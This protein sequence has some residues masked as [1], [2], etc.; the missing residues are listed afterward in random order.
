MDTHPYA[1]SYKED[2]QTGK[3]TYYVSKAECVPDTLATIAADV[4]QNLRSP[5]DQ[6]AYQLVLDAHSGTHPEDKGVVYYPITSAA[7][8]Y[9]ALRTR[10]MKA[11]RQEVID[12]IDATEPYK[13]GKGHALWQLNELNKPDKH[14][15]LV[16]MAF[17]SIG[18]DF[19]PTF[20]TALKKNPLW[21][22]RGASFEKLFA[23]MN[24]LFLREAGSGMA[25][26]GH[27]IYIE[28]LDHEVAHDRRF[29][30]QVTLNAPGV[31][32]PEPALKTL[33]DMANLVD[34]ITTRL[35]GLL[36]P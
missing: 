29:A 18:V 36:L 26:V 15:L 10:N 32:Q 14:Q 1:V 9:P 33:Q 3:R 2:A 27:E 21:N 11:V 5:L 19:T 20:R 24:P 4:I 23:N 35:T 13:G 31:I 30:F 17:N 22:E 16:A 25:D 6:V 8:E 7:S 12:A 34:D 28:P